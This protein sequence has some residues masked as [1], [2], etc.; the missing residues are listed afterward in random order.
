MTTDP[1]VDGYASALF[2]VAKA[3]GTLDEVEDEL[4][5]FARSFESNDQLRS[6]LTDE[7]IPVA[8]RQAIVEDLLGRPQS[9]GGAT[10][11]TVQLVSMVVGSGRGRAREQRLIQAA[12]IS[13]RPR[14]G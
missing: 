9:G 1:R 2:E 14:R 4:F 3:E 12:W 7:L 10:S 8:R 11:T 5:R 6:A 13:R